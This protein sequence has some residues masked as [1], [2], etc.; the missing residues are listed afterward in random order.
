MTTTAR[1]VIIGAGIVG[2]SAA[3][4]LTKLGWRDILIL[5]KGSLL[6]NDGSTSHAPGGVVGLSHS[7]VMTQFAQYS[8][9]LFNSLQ[10]FAADRNTCNPVGGLEVAISTARWQDLK[11]LH[12]EAQAFHAEAHLLSPQE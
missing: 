8:S 1:L 3:Y 7:K 10:P 11:R 9:G 2:A 12:G 5:D 6:E 4:H